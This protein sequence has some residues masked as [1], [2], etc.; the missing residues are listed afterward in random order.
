MKQKAPLGLPS[1]HESRLNRKRQL[2]TGKAAVGGLPPK[3]FLWGLAVLIVG[4]IAYFWN[5]Q[6]ELEEQRRK[7]LTKQRATAQLLAPKLIPMRDAI[8]GGVVELSK[9]AKSSIAA[10]VDWEKLFTSPGIYMRARLADAADLDK[11]REIGGQ[12]LRDGFSA[13]LIRDLTA[14]LPVAGKACKQSNDCETG[15][16]CNEYE[17]CQRPSSPFN[18]RMLYRALHVLSDK[19]EGEVRAAGTDYALIAYDRG[20]DSV[21]KI[22][23]PVAIDVYQRAKYA[24]VVLDEDPPGGLPEP[25]AGVSESESDRVQRVPHFARVGVWELPSGRLLARVRAEA[26]GSLRDVGTVKPPGG[27]ESH[28]ARSR[29]ANSCALALDFQSQLAPENQQ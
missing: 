16:L 26:A 15:E 21:T 20:L 14:K 23:L 18:M 17:H 11:L 29:Q 9:N 7:L 19:W 13:C 27:E 12:S 22:D 8:E 2:V 6:A 5:A 10:E 25:I 24:I 28:A 3:V 1:L 4:G